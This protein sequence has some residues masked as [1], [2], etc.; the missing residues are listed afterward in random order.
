MNA[1]LLPFP[2]CRRPLLACWVWLLKLGL[3]IAD[4]DDRSMRGTN[5]RFCIWVTDRD[6]KALR[7]INY[8]PV[9]RKTPVGENIPF[10]ALGPIRTE[11]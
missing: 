2:S 4:N 5:G 3:V 11:L 9:A 6:V 7:E 8:S 10:D 1:H